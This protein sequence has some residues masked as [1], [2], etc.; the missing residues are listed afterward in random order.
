MSYTYVVED[1]QNDVD[2]GGGRGQFFRDMSHAPGVIG[3]AD[4]PVFC[5][6][7]IKTDHQVPR[8]DTTSTDLS[9]LITQLAHEIGQSISAQLMKGNEKE[10]KVTNSQSVGL[11]SLSTDTNSLTMT[12]VKLVM[13]SDVK[14]PPSFRGDGTDKLSI[15]EW[16]EQ[17]DVYLRKRGVPIGEQA[18][19]I[20]SRLGGRARDI[21]KVTLRSNPSLKP[22][23]D[24]RVIIDILKQHFSELTYS[25]MPLADFYN[26]LP[27]AGENA[28]DYWIR[29]NK[30]VDVAEEC[31]KRQRRNL[32]EP[33]K[34]VTM[35]FVKHCP[36]PALSA[37]LKFKTADKWKASEIQEHLDDHQAQLKIQRQ[38]ARS[39]YSGVERNATANVQ[40]AEIDESTQV[41]TSARS[42]N[43][44]EVVGHVGTVSDH[45]SLQNLIAQLDRMLKQNHQAAVPAPY[46]SSGPQPFQ[47]P[48]RVCQAT[49]HSTTMHCR[50][51]G[52]CL[53]CCK[54]GHRRRECHKARSR[55]CVPGVHS[56][57]GQQPLN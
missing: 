57:Q 54:P 30:A 6:T 1:A 27:T 34:E 25:A 46:M 13:Q 31:L 41:G 23:E 47:K 16:E 22:A 15:H 56:S 50:R 39:K 26:T 19:E 42:Q 51:D 43:Q 9:Y 44:M 40:A 49:D 18:Q 11:E 48:C 36:D 4:S 45:T 28:M 10:E 20:M 29:L 12:G 17:I 35:M 2:I 38:R 37:V 53:S 7:R 52:L 3:F 8:S 55:A 24:P 32:E 5:S 14:E 33:S 21:I